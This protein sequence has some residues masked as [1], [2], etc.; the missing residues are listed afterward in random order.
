MTMDFLPTFARLAGAGIPEDH[1]LDGIDLM[2]ILKGETKAPPRNLHWLFGGSWAVCK[3]SWKLIGTGERPQSLFHLEDDLSENNNLIIKG[4]NLL[5]LHTL[6]SRYGSR[7]DVIYIDPPYYFDQ[8]KS[9]DTFSY[10]SNFKLSTWLTFM[11][12]RLEISKKLLSSKGVIF[13][14]F[15]PLRIQTIHYY[16]I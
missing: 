8:K 15:L 9:S 12:N 4:N 7:V 16:I 14:E 11:K 2:P 13:I 5:A 6:K 1:K 3:G 10:N